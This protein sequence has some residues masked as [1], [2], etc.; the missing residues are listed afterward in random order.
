MGPIRENRFSIKKNPHEM[1]RLRSYG[2]IDEHTEKE[3]NCTY[4]VL[5]PSSFFFFFVKND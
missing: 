3:K 5:R 1:N 2:V 4:A